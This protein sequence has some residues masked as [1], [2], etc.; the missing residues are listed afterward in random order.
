MSAYQCGQHVWVAENSV[1]SRTGRECHVLHALTCHVSR[2]TYH[3]ELVF[4]GAHTSYQLPTFERKVSNSFDFIVSTEMATQVGNFSVKLDA[5]VRSG[6]MSS[7]SGT[8]QVPL[9][10]ASPTRQLQPPPVIFR[11]TVKKLERCKLHHAKL[12]D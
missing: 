4:T 8:L 7:M 10:A 3:V 1:A 12:H 5:H 2:V 6:E 9:P 11:N